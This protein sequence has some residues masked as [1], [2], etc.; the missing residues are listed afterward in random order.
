MQRADIMSGLRRKKRVAAL[1][2][3]VGPPMAT[4]TTSYSSL[5]AAE[6]TA[7]SYDNHISN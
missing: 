3:G 7:N 5:T 1:Q 2:A 4:R 6:E